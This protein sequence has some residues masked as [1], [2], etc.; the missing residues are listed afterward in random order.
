[1]LPDIRELRTWVAQANAASRRVLE[2]CGFTLLG[3]EE[4]R[5]EKLPEAIAMCVYGRGREVEPR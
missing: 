1:M 2:K 4:H 3:V 5:W